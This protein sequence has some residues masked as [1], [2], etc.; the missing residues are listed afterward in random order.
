MWQIKIKLQ[1]A[2]ESL[3]VERTKL[4]STLD[5]EDGG[6]LGDTGGVVTVPYRQ[7]RYIRTYGQRYHRKDISHQP[8]LTYRV[9]YG[10]G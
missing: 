4:N 9:R 5:F 10:G 8:C 7:R 2:N 6:E 1:L 3:V